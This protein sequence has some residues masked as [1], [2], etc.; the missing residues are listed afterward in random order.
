MTVWSVTA[1]EICRL[2]GRDAD[3]TALM[4]D[5]LCA[6]AGGSL[7]PAALRL[8]LKTQEPDGGIDAAVDGAVLA[9]RD[10]SGF[11]PVPTCWQFKACSTAHVKARKGKKD[12]KGGQEKALRTEIRKPYARQLLKDGYGYRF[13]I[14]DCLTPEKRQRWEAW[15]LDEARAVNPDAPPPRVIDAVLLAQWCSCYAGI[16]RQLRPFLSAVRDFST[17]ARLESA[18]SPTFVEVES[19]HA[20]TAALRAFADLAIPAREPVLTVSGE[21]GI[22][23]SRCVVE[24]LRT[25][26][27]IGA[28]V[29]ATDDESAAVDV[30]NQVLREPDYRAICVVDG[31]SAATRSRLSRLLAADVGRLRVI[32]IDNERRDEPL[33]EG[34]IRL[35]PLERQDV[36]RIL[37]ANF[38]KIPNERR[39]AIADLAAGFVRMAVDICRNVHLLPEGGSLAALVPL[40]RDRYLACRL[41]TR[42]RAVVELV[43]LLARV[44][45]RGEPAHELRD[46]CAACPAAGL[47]PEEITATAA[48]IRKAPG[49]IAV[50][51]R[52]LY[53]T[54]RVVAQAAFRSAW[55][56]WVRADPEAFF[57]A[58]PADLEDALA[59]QTRDAGTEEMRRLFTSFH[60]S[61]L[62]RLSYAS[63]SD[64]ATMYRLF[65]LAEVEPETILPHLADWIDA[66]TPEQIVGLNHL[67]HQ[68]GSRARVWA[69][70]RE[71][72]WL[73]EWLLRFP[74][75]YPFAERIL[76]RLALVETETCGNNA[77]E[78]W[79]RSCRPLLS[80]T[81]IP[82]FERLRRLSSG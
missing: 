58:L 1:D 25:V 24:S 22:G 76:Y 50:G 34:E 77:T 15:L 75:F 33:A 23:K 19:R 64:P 13:C 6:T 53:V 28:L 51:P 16:V 37:A 27:G 5:L 68:Q 32:A 72:V 52:Y 82:F 66:A 40:I 14:T 12:T 69:A 73:A 9:D 2:Q 55:E 74:E 49:F 57:R 10:P 26:P 7:A 56:R 8:T 48:D 11:L 71:L 78:I 47:T 62:Q 44:G 81:A 43:S 3:M 59:R 80:G 35:A 61:W 60:E 70:R 18:E 41:S 54:P 4:N 30:I 63:L 38:P 36:E 67:P 45:Y 42:Q 20:A 39:W 79:C 31:L 46:L 17:W 21:A 65:R 29:V